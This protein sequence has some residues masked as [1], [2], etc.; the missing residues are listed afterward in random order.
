MKSI[1]RSFTAALLCFVAA[2]SSQAQ[3]FTWAKN[4]GAA[5][6]TS[7]MRPTANTIDASGN[8]YVLGIFSGTYDFDP[9]AAVVNMTGNFNGQDLFIQKFS[10]TGTLLWAKGILSVGSFTQSSAI[11]TD[12][13]GNVFITG[14]FD[15]PVDFDPSSTTNLV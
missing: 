12:N 11:K 4:I 10:P 15:S 13:S 6:A 5:N 9:G 3:T 1:I 8:Y 2:Q 14:S 7:Y